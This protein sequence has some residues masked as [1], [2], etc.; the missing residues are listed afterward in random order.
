LAV[1]VSKSQTVHWPADALGVDIQ[2]SAVVELPLV[3]ER[4]LDERTQE[5]LTRRRE[6]PI[7]RWRRGWLMRRALLAADLV[8]LVAAFTIAEAADGAAADRFYNGET[9]AFLLSLPLWVVVA[10]VYG[11]Y[12]RDEERTD[13]STADDLVG[14]FHLVTVGSWLVF[15]SAWLL[16]LARPQLTKLALFWLL[17][18]VSIG[19]ARALARALCHR[20]ISYLQNTVIVGAGDVGQL[21]ARKALQHPEYGLNVVG[22]VDDRPRERRPD[23]GHLALLGGIDELREIVE[24][25]DIE[26][27]VVAFSN[28]SSET[29]LELIRELSERQVQI[30]IV[31]RFFD[32]VGPGLGIHTVEGL[33]LIGLPPS[34][35][36]HSS[37]L[38]KRTLDIVVSAAALALLTIPFLVI[39]LL[40]KLETAGPVFFRQ[41]RMGSEG[42][43]R[44]WKFRTMMADADARKAEYAHLNQHAAPGGDPRMFKI[45]DDPRVTAVGR[46]LRRY[47]LDELPQLL[48]VLRGEMSIVGPRPLILEEDQHVEH[49]GRRRLQLKPGITGLWQ[50]TGRNDIPFEEMVKL[51]YRYV[52]GWSLLTDL[53]LMLRTVPIL[54]RPSAG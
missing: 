24:E 19:I 49:W 32:V 8:G 36:P 11:L 41:V 48:N 33:P 16:G 26:R 3:S 22:L 50:V 42:T 9:V 37:R 10:K 38:L 5:L 4:R 47:S 15:A 40:I 14:V 17:A 52:S 43:F 30:D 46:W 13:H 7:G 28:D 39:A 45:P 20:H 53:R 31:P 44:I 6:A 23:L 2:G 25:L 21:I 18:N 12:D 1:V 54:L 35:L 29:L 51:D 27:V 34:R